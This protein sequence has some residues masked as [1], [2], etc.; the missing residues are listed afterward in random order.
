MNGWSIRYDKNSKAY[1][2]TNENIR[3][4]QVNEN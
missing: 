1:I 3:N 2:I 4:F